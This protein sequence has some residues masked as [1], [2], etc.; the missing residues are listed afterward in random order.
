[1]A[2][3][4]VLKKIFI[5]LCVL[6]LLWLGGFAAFAVGAI[7]ASPEDEDQTTDAIVVLTGGNNRIQEGLALFAQGKAAH[8]FISGVHENVKK[9]EIL[10]LWDGD[11]TLPPCCVTLGYEATTTTQNAA[12]T[13]GWIE[14]ED[15]SSIR[16]VTGDYHIAR[17]MM[18]MHHALPGVDIYAHPVHQPDLNVRTRH[19]WELL[20]SEYHK[21]LYRWVQLLFSKKVPLSNL[22]ELTD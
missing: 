13:R 7:M 16:L 21:S 14:K 19:Y 8:L 3:M 9:R 11:Q 22:S 1:M 5:A 2:I 20:F 17:S 6:V 10:S 12:E 18:E 4:R 15:Y